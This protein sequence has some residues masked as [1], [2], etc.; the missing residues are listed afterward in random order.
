MVCRKKFPD[1]FSTQET[2][3]QATLTENY[4]TAKSFQAYGHHVNV[5][6]FLGLAALIS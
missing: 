3:Y 2:F 6:G 1:T 4:R 5:Y